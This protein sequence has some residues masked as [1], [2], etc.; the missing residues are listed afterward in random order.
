MNAMIMDREDPDRWE[1]VSHVAA[2]KIAMVTTQL[3][4]RLAAEWN[5]TPT[6]TVSLTNV[7]VEHGI[8]DDVAAIV[9]DPDQQTETVIIALKAVLVIFL[10]FI[11]TISN[12]VVIHVM[13]LDRS[14][15]T[16]GNLF[17]ASLAIADLCV[18]IFVIPFNIFDILS[19]RG[20]QAHPNAVRSIW[21]TLDYFFTTSSIMNLVLLNLDRF[22]SITSPI[23]YIRQRTRRRAL[24][25]IA[26]VWGVPVVF[27]VGPAT[28]WKFAF[29]NVPVPSRTVFVDYTVGSWLMAAGAVFIYIIPLFIL[30]AIYSQI[31]RAIHR[32]SKMDVGRSSIASSAM[33]TRP[34]SSRR[35]S[36]SQHNFITEHE[37]QRLKG[38]YEKT[39]RRER[40]ER[41]LMAMIR[42]RSR[43]YGTGAREIRRYASIDEE[44]HE[45]HGDENEEN[46]VNDRNEDQELGDGCSI[47]EGV[48]D[49]SA[50]SSDG[51]LADA[52]SNDAEHDDDDDDGSIG[53]YEIREGEK[54]ALMTSLKNIENEHR[55]SIIGTQREDTEISI[56]P[57][58]RARKRI[59]RMS[60]D[61]ATNSPK[62]HLSPCSLKPDRLEC[63]LFSNGMVM[64]PNCPNS[65][66]SSRGSSPNRRLGTSMDDTCES[67]NRLNR[68]P[69]KTQP[70]SIPTTPERATTVTSNSQPNT[71]QNVPLH[72]NGDVMHCNGILQKAFTE[73]ILT[74]MQESSFT[75]SSENIETSPRSDERSISPTESDHV[76]LSDIESDTGLPTSPKQRTSF[77]FDLINEVTHC[78]CNNVVIDPRPSSRSL[79]YPKNDNRNS[80]TFPMDVSSMNGF[81]SRV[82]KSLSSSLTALGGRG[83]KALMLLRKQDKA[84]KQLGIILTCLIV[85]WTPYFFQVL[86]YSFMYDV[87]NTTAM[88]IAVYLGYAHSF[89]NPVLYALFNLRFQRAFRHVLCGCCLRT[90]TSPRLPCSVPPSLI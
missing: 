33:S 29:T 80:L 55:L 17:T 67:M 1:S 82:R 63:D 32:R 49:H 81:R 54:E 18:G 56:S 76:I 60:I 5:V 53:P 30:C 65:R 69:A 50:P 8:I 57:I 6:V 11:V 7:E 73:S 52:E 78:R 48:N 4:E 79:S 43:G 28:T 77:S 88:T 40:G 74:S 16:V 58:T 3:A 39:V 71:D 22:W 62:P 90:E 36:E 89:F 35:D 42:R 19:V 23:K 27:I 24:L 45:V 84:A 70:P 31:Y 20:W 87:S 85:C 2:S 64:C 68:S 38:I 15:H 12:A 66:G 75:T 86:L 21:I 25:L 26:C 61:S 72:Q 83:S 34:G 51:K 47:Y 14:L 10:S 37:L 46:E 44:D 41:Q 59:D 9:S 13:R